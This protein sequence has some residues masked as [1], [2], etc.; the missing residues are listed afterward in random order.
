VHTFLE[1]PDH[2][3]L[4][5]W[6]RYCQRFSF[7]RPKLDNVSAVVFRAL[8]PIHE[9]VESDESVVILLRA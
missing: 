3:R 5:S 8:E 9:V 6:D 1:M 4:T 7:G 2:G